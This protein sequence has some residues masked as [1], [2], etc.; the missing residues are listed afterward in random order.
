MDASRPRWRGGHARWTDA[1][2]AG[3]RALEAAGV[4]IMGTSPEAIDL[5]EDRDRFARCST[6]STSPT[7]RSAMASAL[8]EARSC[9][10]RASAIPLLV[11]PS[12][13]LGGRGMEHR[14]R[15]RAACARYMAEAT[16]RF[17]RPPRVSGHA[18]WKA[19]SSATLDALCDGEDVY[20]RRHPGAHRDGRHPLGRLGLLP[21]RPSRCRRRCR[22]QH[23]RASPASIALALGVRGLVNIQ[24][25]VEGR[26]R[27]RH[28]GQP[29]REPHGALH[30]EGH[31]RALSEA[32]QPHHGGGEAGRA[33]ASRAFREAGPLLR[34]GGC[35]AL[36]PLP[37][38]RCAA[39]GRKC[40]PPAR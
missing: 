20:V 40:A 10:P 18:S 8:E 28:R 5:A 6:S 26:G 23:A 15:R 4:P 22:S 29:A 16:A 30:L 33:E 37:G 2:E 36:R 31:G 14:L 7:R 3:A 34:E 25:A 19:P 12:Y 27:L 11:R 21:C 13:V 35:H 32:R 1:A 39:W 38:G 9:C 17:A 24:F